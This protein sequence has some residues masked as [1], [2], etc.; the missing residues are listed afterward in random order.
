MT[1]AESSDREESDLLC[2]WFDLMRDR[3][4]LHRYEKEL[5]VRA[6]EI[7]LEDR[8]ERLQQ[9]LHDRLAEERKNK[10][11]KRNVFNCF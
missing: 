10:L 4:E 2:E 1:L 5:L 6:Q 7:Q 9:E 3:S 11:S 8:Y